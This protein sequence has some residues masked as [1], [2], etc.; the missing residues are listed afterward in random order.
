MVPRVHR[1]SQV[2]AGRVGAALG[3]PAGGGG[4]RAALAARLHGNPL[5]LAALAEADA[6]LDREIAQALDPA[7]VVAAARSLR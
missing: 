1:A 4:P 2:E 7:Q 5:F 6:D 3:A